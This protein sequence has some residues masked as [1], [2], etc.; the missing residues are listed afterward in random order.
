M[1]KSVFTDTYSNFTALL[2]AARLEAGLTQTE[3]A[4]K[5]GRPQSFVSKIEKG[6]RR[7]DV[8]EFCAIARALGE[9]PASLL[10]QLSL[11]E[12]IVL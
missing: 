8:V 7:V 9:E 3:L 4:G 11:P 1:S 2:V 5:L 6:E 12:H 10:A